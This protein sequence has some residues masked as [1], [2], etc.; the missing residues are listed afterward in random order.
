MEEKEIQGIDITI[1]YP[2]NDV[3]EMFLSI[4]KQ[5]NLFETLFINKKDS[6]IEECYK[7]RNAVHVLAM[8]VEYFH[9]PEHNWEKQGFLEDIKKEPQEVIYRKM[10]DMV[11]KIWLEKNNNEYVRQR[12]QI[13]KNKLWDKQDIS[14]RELPIV[15]E[16]I[17]P[18]RYKW[19][20]NV[21]VDKLFQEKLEKEKSIQEQADQMSMSANQGLVFK[22]D[23][24][25]KIKDLKS[26]L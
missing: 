15:S 2:D 18:A 6:K 5:L 12:T 22:E 16:M 11:I 3:M 26:E 20:S 25:D 19:E 24:E 9:R 14:V 7:Q 13:R 8:I 17:F 1:K 21:L 4:G 23:T 10:A